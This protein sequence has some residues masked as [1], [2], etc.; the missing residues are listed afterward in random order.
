[1][2]DSTWPTNLRQKDADGAKADS[3]SRKRP[4]KDKV[5]KEM[6]TLVSDVLQDMAQ[7]SQPTTRV[8][9]KGTKGINDITNLRAQ[10]QQLEVDIASKFLVIDEHF[11]CLKTVVDEIKESNEHKHEM[12]EVN[13]QSFVD[14]ITSESNNT[15]IVKAL[16]KMHKHHGNEISGVKLSM[17]KMQHATSAAVHGVSRHIEALTQEIAST[18]E[19]VDNM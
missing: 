17:D 13:F 12:W 19:N 4:S 1:M 15:K 6:R 8:S 18:K 2:I 3:R 11:N 9:A 5:Y 16:Q 7:V 14:K 10:V